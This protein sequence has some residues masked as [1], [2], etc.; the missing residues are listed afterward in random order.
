MAGTNYSVKKLA[1]MA[2]V[3]VRTLHIYDKMGLLKPSVRTN[4]RYRL[5]GDTELLQLQQILFYKELE[6]PLKEIKEILDKPGFNLVKALEGHKKAIHSRRDRLNTLIKTIDKTIL[7]LKNKT[8]LNTDE[9]YDG[10]SR[11]DAA[12]YRKEATEKYGQTA[13]ERSENYLNK[14]SK[15]EAMDL[16]A[17]QKEISAQLALLKNENPASVSVQS[18]IHQH[19]LII[20]QFWG[21]AGDANKQAAAYKGLGDLYVAD[22]RFTMVNGVAQP[23]LNLFLSEAMTYYADHELV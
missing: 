4:A 6:L 19:Y 1:K 3:T 8:M 11:E 16:A 10:L 2:G 5:Y 21:T 15:Q 7:T 13:V 23:E 17:Q 14:L 20:R 9:L 18:L 12:A 22:E